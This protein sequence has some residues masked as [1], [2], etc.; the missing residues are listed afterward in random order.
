M[1]GTELSRMAVHGE[2]HDSRCEQSCW[3]CWNIGINTRS[4][5]AS[6]CGMQSRLAKLRAASRPSA[7]GGEVYKNY[8][9]L[10][11]FEVVILRDLM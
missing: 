4:G 10:C 11:V 3:R 5:E 1:A 9:E 7:S 6:V 2:G 8:R